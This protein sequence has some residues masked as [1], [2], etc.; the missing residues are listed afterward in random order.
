M[1]A[2]V[3]TDFPEYTT[4]LC[5][6]LALNRH[7]AYGLTYYTTEIC[8]T[9]V[10][11][12]NVGDGNRAIEDFNFILEKDPSDMMVTFNRALL[13]HETGD[14]RGAIKDYTTV[15]KAYP[16]FLLGYQ[17][18][19]EAKRMIGDVRGAE[20]DEEHVIK[21]QVAHRYG[22]ASAASKKVTTRKKS[23]KN[24]EDYNKLVVE[25]EEQ[26]KQY[27]SEYRGKVQNRNTE[28][29]LQ[30]MYVLTYYEEENKLK[31]AI[32]YCRDVE[33]VNGRKILPEKAL[34]WKCSPTRPISARPSPIFSAGAA[35]RTATTTKCTPGAKTTGGS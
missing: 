30:P 22:Y 31:Q 15:I 17:K 12:A 2:I 10:M 1:I 32:N 14:Y 25:D 6:R 24:M 33:K 11:I 16:N 13:L 19:A 4:S 29:T 21:E 18:R 20:R 8:G 7:C 26:E 35:T 28:T 5:G 3:T 27:K 34:P 9:R 23:E